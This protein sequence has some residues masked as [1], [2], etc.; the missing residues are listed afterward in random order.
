MSLLSRIWGRKSAETRQEPI[1]TDNSEHSDPLQAMSTS[2]W[3]IQ[4]SQPQLKTVHE[5][6]SAPTAIAMDDDSK[7]FAMDSAGETALKLAGAGAASN[8]A[9]P[10]AI[11]NWYNS[12]G[13]IG[14][15][16]C[17]LIAQH[18]LIDKACSMPGEDAARN[19]WELKTDNKALDEDTRRTISEFDTSIGLHRHITEFNRFRNIFGV[20]VALFDVRSDDA[21]YYEKPF[22]INGVKKGSYRGIVQVDPYWMTPMLTAK[23]TSEPFAQHF[24]EPD[25]WI[26][27]G[28]K[29]HRS[30]LI[31]T[32]GP[33]PPDIL[34]PTYVFGGV[35]LV[36]RIYERVYASERTANE[37]PLL[38]MSKRTTV[39]KTD[40]SKMAANKTAFMKRLMEWVAMRDNHAVKIAGAN[41]SMEQLDTSLADFDSVIMSQYQ[42]VAAIAKV[43]ATKLLGTPPKGFNA[44]GEFETVSYHEELESIQK[45]VMLPLLNRHY[46][47]LAKSLGIEARLLVVWNP[48][49]A[50]SS[51]ARADLNLKKAQTHQYYMDIGA[52]SAAEVR[53]TLVEDR[54]SGYNSLSD[55]AHVNTVPGL[56]PENITMFERAAAEHSRADAM[57]KR[58]DKGEAMYEYD[59]ALPDGTAA[60]VDP[61]ECIQRLLSILERLSSGGA[62]IPRSNVPNDT[63]SGTIR[64]VQPS[65]RGIEPSVKGIASISR[66][67][68]ADSLPGYHYGPL[69]VKVETPRGNFRVGDGWKTLM[70]HDY[71]FIKGSIGADGDDLDCFVGPKDYDVGGKVFIVNQ[72][73]DGQF[74]EHKVML[75]FDSASAALDGYSNSYSKDWDGM[76]SIY[77]ISFPHFIQWL[78][79]GDLNQPYRV[80]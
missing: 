55:D 23:S 53:Q 45:N 44:T 28:K 57:M 22:N 79:S 41:E 71:G 70:P 9:V 29:Y 40:I 24:Y 18:W 17:A 21:K 43:P 46:A 42:L 68:A 52:V 19:G 16:S 48:V 58:A 65:V 62:P 11:Q 60:P 63:R 6:P 77:E 67:Q 14:H 8:Y 13:F 69:E 3:P 64:T 26:I 78:A 56:T 72:F 66:P 51:S 32:R 80:V 15:Q 47:L 7:S 59:E 37:A 49:D 74:D 12:Q 75:G 39:F 5:Y 25:F 27:S 73:I 54:N 4:R 10:E 38:A 31:I 2:E 20:R 50:V 33:I 30:H 35:P 36:Q 1:I 61:V 76:E 34:K